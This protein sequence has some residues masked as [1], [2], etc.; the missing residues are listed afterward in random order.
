MKLRNAVLDPA[1]LKKSENSLLDLWAS[2]ME[3]FVR[4]GIVDYDLYC[5]APIRLL[6][7]LKE[8]NGKSVTDLRKILRDGNRKQTWNVVARWVEGIF[9]LEKDFSWDELNQNDEERRKKMLKYICAVNMKKT[10]GKDVSDNSAVFESAINNREMLKKQI[11]LYK[12]D[13]VICCGT[14]YAYTKVMETKPQRKSTKHG[15]WYYTE[16]SGTVVVAFSH[17]EAMLMYG[18]EASNRKQEI[19]R[20]HYTIPNQRPK[21]KHFEKI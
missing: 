7:V 4:D 10:S 16:P 17:P 5:G 3:G 9:N 21:D 18:K 1:E 14:D 2:S 15:I 8:V 6:F 11:E 20:Q 12:P 13:F 19:D